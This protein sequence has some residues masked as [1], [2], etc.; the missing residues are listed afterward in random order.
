MSKAFIA[1]VTIFTLW[2]GTNSNA[3]GKIERDCIFSIQKTHDSGTGQVK[4]KHGVYVFLDKEIDPDGRER[5]STTIAVFRN[6]KKISKF[7]GSFK[8]LSTLR[9]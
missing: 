5:E 4:K 2:I 7:G 8:V 3:I 9:S 1:T 6:G